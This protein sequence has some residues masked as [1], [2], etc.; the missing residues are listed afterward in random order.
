M[1]TTYNGWTNYETWNV[2]LYINNDITLYYTAVEYVKRCNQFG[3]NVS[4]AAFSDV[5]DSIMGTKTPDGVSWSDENL[6]TD[7]LNEML[8]DLVDW[9]TSNQGNLKG[10]K[11]THLEIVPIV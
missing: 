10:I 8:E 7:E 11:V 5:L 9:L 6:D 3:R 4:Y 2:S 1:D